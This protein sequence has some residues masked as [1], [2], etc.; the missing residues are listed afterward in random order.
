MKP[1]KIDTTI[2]FLKSHGWRFK[3][4]HHK[5]FF[6]LYPPK[7]ITSEESFLYRIPR[8]AE[9]KDF[10][11]YMLHLVFSIAELYELNKWELLDLLSKSLPQIQQDLEVQLKEIAMKQKLLAFAS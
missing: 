6:L 1:A 7:E 4:K 11:E 5:Q 10:K 3:K 8:T 2:A 9:G